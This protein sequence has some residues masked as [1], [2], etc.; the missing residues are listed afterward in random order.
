MKEG[1]YLSVAG[2]YI[3]TPSI[4]ADLRD[5]EASC[6]VATSELGLTATLERIRRTEGFVGYRI[7][8]T[9]NDIGVVSYWSRG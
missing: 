7:Q 9:K 5:A 6:G 3:I 1:E 2:I 4:L 8:G